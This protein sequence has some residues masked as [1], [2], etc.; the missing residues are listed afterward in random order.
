MIENVPGL[1]NLTLDR[2]HAARAYPTR[3]ITP[4]RQDRQLSGDLTW[5]HGAHNIKFG[6][7][8]YWLQTNFLSSQQIG[9]IFNFTGQFTQNP[10]TSTGGSALA[11]FLLG[12]VL[13]PAF[14]IGRIWISARRSPIS[15][16][17]T[18]G[19]SAGI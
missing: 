5:N 13:Q 9:G 12:D 10:A 15:S 1:A 7:Q 3:R 17:R 18:T 11:D 2:F 4:A 19:R 8:Q 14:P 16:F 6:A